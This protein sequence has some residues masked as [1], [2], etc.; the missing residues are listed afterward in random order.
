MALRAARMR[1]KLAVDRAAAQRMQVVRMPGFLKESELRAIDALGEEHARIHGPPAASAPNRPLWRTQYLN[2]GGLARGREPALLDKL[3]DL[4][5]SV[6]GEHFGGRAAAADAGA[7]C[8]EL[9]SCG[10]GS[11]LDDP[12]HFDSG[13][14][15][16][17]DVMLD[18]ADEGGH[19]ETLEADGAMRRHAFERGDAIVFPSYKYHSVAQVT[20]GLR[21]VLVLEL[22]QGDEKL[23]DH[24]CTVA[25]GDCRAL[26]LG[27]PA[28]EPRA[29]AAW[30]PPGAT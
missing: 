17:L 3:V 16:T 8:V 9:H 11:S 27:V 6:D 24:R 29:E 2:A 18:E 26:K 5:K 30:L 19:F 25:R 10:V 22:W 15:V 7:R 12:M 4:A 14:I 1:A 28:K 20:K 23:C 13:S 21:R